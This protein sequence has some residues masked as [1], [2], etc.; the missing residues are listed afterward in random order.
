VNALSTAPT[1]NGN[2][3]VVANGVKTTSFSYS[4]VVDPSDALS[5]A[6]I[7]INGPDPLGNY[8]ALNDSSAFEIIGPAFVLPTWAW[9]FALSLLLAAIAAV[10]GSTASSIAALR[11]VA[12][13]HG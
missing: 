11:S 7:S 3:A 5:V 4:Y 6:S 13:D 10:P 2:P 12:L 8:G 9:P 1:L